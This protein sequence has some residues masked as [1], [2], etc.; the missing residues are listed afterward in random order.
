MVK[1][2]KKSEKQETNWVEWKDY[3]S[4]VDELK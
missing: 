4:M 3:I 1:A 2:H